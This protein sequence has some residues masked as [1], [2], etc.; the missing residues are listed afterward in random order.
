MAEIY[1]LDRAGGVRSPRFRAYLTLVEHEHA[2]AAC[3]PMGGPA[4]VA[5][6]WTPLRL[7]WHAG[8]RWAIARAHGA[9]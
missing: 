7:P 6:G 2:L 9:L 1:R 8:Y 4:A 3:N 5:L